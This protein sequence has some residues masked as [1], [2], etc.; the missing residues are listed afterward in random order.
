MYE[1]INIQYQ[2][3]YPDMYKVDIMMQWLT[4]LLIFW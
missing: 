1:Y 4:P 3:Y 2:V